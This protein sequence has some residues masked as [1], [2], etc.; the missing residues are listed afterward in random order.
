M[1]VCSGGIVEW[2]GHND[3]VGLLVQLANMPKHPQ[4]VPINQLVRVEEILCLNEDDFDSF[5][6]IRTIAVARIMILSLVYDYLPVE[7]L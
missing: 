7:S 5:D 3:R 1:N 2:V 4:S 6:F